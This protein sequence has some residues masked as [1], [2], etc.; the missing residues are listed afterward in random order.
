MTETPTDVLVAGYRE[1]GEATRDFE[2]LAQRRLRP[3]PSTGLVFDRRDG[4]S[5]AENH[6]KN[7]RGAAGGRGAAEPP[8][9]SA[10]L[11]RRRSPPR[12]IARRDPP[13][14]RPAS[15]WSSCPCSDRSGRRGPDPGADALPFEFDG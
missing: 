4:P 15:R 8:L 2:S 11:A 9:G 13:R 14:R 10:R 1:I 7:A 5:L 6:Q 12:P 3:Q